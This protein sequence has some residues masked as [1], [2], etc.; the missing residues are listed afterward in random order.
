M[1]GRFIVRVDHVASRAA[2][3]AIVARLVVRARQAEERVEQSGFLQ[4]EENGIG[5]EKCPE[6]TLAELHIRPAGFFVQGRNS[7]FGLFRASALKNA[8]DIAGLRYFPPLDW[9]EIGQ[10]TL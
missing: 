6:S 3:V 1:L 8:E 10:Y 9:I 2:A 4:A 7:N 5:A